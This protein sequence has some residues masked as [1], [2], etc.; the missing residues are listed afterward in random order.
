MFTVGAGRHVVLLVV[1]AAALAAAVLATAVRAI[2]VRRIEG[3]AAVLQGALGP[4]GSLRMNSEY[5]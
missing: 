5:Y 1:R 4:M 2:A 3:H